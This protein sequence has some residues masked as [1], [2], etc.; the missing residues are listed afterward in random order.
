MKKI[1]FFDLDGTVYLNNSLL[2]FA[3]E[4]FDYL[5]ENKYTYVFLTNNSSVNKANYLTKLTNLNIKTTLNNI[6][7]SVDHLLSYLKETNVK[8]LYL[9]GTKDLEEELV[10]HNYQ[11]I[12]NYQKG[13]VERVVVGFDKTLTY[14]KLKEASLYIQDGVKVISTHVDKRCPY[15][16]GYYIPD[17]GS[18]IDLLNS[19]SPIKDLVIL[20][21]PHE[22]MILNILKEKGFNKEDALI[23]GDRFYTDVLCGV[24][25]KVESGLILTGESKLADLE[26]LNYQPTYLFKDLN[27]V[28]NF[29]KK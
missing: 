16:N 27:E 12:T 10:N 8:K 20:G 14:K 22:A 11:I 28:L 3:K 17:A 24:N 9:L 2:P 29:I 6:Y 15:D 19:T 4:L 21:K 5:Y 1:I 26:G 7:S 23:I 18:I 25:A 13:G